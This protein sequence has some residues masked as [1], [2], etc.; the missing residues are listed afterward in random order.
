MLDAPNSELYP[1]RKMDATYPAVQAFLD[2]H[3]LRYMD[4]NGG[5][6]DFDWVAFHL[7]CFVNDWISKD[8]ARAICRSLTDRGFA[9]Y[10]RGLWDEDGMPAG[11]GYRITEAG[12]RYLETLSS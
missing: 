3:V 2:Q 1:K 8:M 11:A 7:A 9:E 5:G 10:C 6:R 4:H 12:R